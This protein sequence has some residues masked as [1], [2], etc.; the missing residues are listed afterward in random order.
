MKTFPEFAL[1]LLLGS[2]AVAQVKITTMSLPDGTVKTPYS[3]TIETTGGDTPFDWSSVGLPAGL[4]LKPSEDTRS[5]TLTGTPTKPST[6][7]FDVSVEGRGGHMSTVDYTLTIQGGTSHSADLTW[8]AGA[9]NIAGYNLYRGTT[10]GGPYSQLNSSLL[11][12]NSYTDSNVADGT[13]YY[14]VATEVNKQGEESGY[15]AQAVAVIP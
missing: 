12:T 1:I 5:A 7:Q 6:H 9:K 4:K 3:A 15:C 14:Y 13:T 8:K 2:L 11:S 10:S